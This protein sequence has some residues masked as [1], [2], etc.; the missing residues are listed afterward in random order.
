MIY[1]S[2]NIFLFISHHF[3]EKLSYC[4]YRLV[5]NQLIIWIFPNFLKK[6]K[7]IVYLFQTK[8]ISENKISEI[9]LFA[10]IITSVK[11]QSK[12]LSA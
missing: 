10:V 3:Y 7:K 5:C 8:N 9:S 6:I 2:N 1:L 11:F 12:L 4:L